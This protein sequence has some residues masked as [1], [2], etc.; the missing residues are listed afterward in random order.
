MGG[1][2][3]PMTPPGHLEIIDDASHTK[4]TSL[5]SRTSSELAEA[6]ASVRRSDPAL[7][8]NELQG[9][10]KIT[11]SG[12]STACNRPRAELRGSCP[13][14]AVVSRCGHRV[15]VEQI[16]SGEGWNRDAQHPT[17]VVYFDA[18]GDHVHAGRRPRTLTAEGP[19]SHADRRRPGPSV[20]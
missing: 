16:R 14:W 19:L 13:V 17:V 8:L 11:K 5:A 12:C 2:V 20:E 10:E 4:P 9:H 6:L 7:P 3:Q 18:V 1:G 15:M